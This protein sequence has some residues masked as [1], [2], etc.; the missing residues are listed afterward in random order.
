MERKGATARRE[1]WMLTADAFGEIDRGSVRAKRTD[2][3]WGVALREPSLAWGWCVTL[4]E[5][6]RTGI[7]WL[8]AAR[9]LYTQGDV[10]AGISLHSRGR[11]LLF[12]VN[13]HRGIAELCT[14]SVRNETV[15]AGALR[16]SGIPW[17]AEV[18]LEYN[19]LTERC[20]GSLGSRK[21]FDI[22]LPW[23][24]VKPL[25]APDAVEVVTTSGEESGP[26]AAFYGHLRLDGA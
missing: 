3:G 20:A 7:Y 23:R 22:P 10:A 14:L 5:R 2:G 16:I 9:V 21:L 25:E 1:G 6:F 19:A 24:G 15:C 4:P 11:G 26:A 8:T 18:V 17:P 12:R 13:A